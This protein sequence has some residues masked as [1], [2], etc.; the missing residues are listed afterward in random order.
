[1]NRAAAVVAALSLAS[2]SA[3]RIARADSSAEDMATARK[4]FNQGKELRDKGDLK[5]ALEKFKQAHALGTTPITGYELGKT[6]LQL[7]Q[8]VEAREAFLSVARLE[9]AK[10]E[11]K[12][13]AKARAESEKLADDL[14]AR[15][16]TVHVVLD[17]L[18]AGATPTV[19]IDGVALPATAVNVPYAVNPGKH[20][21]LVTVQGAEGDAKGNVEVKEGE[22]KDVTV[23]VSAL[24]PVQKP[25]VTTTTTTLPP[26]PPPE[27]KSVSPLVFIGFGVGAAGLIA[28]GVTGLMSMSKASTVKDQCDGN[29]CP[30]TVQ[31]DLD[32]GKTL[33]TIST[34]S[35]AVGAAGIVVGVIGLAMGGS[36]S[37]SDS[38]DKSAKVH[39]TP[40]I[41]LGSA[42]LSGAF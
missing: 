14:K 11:S 26:P 27:K 19:S 18:A 40:W 37:K 35:F 7:G 17:G 30:R 29:T 33:G 16:P 1:M 42:G 8:L 3:P 31:S 20:D 38:G 15:I 12:N 39:V 34:I 21:I 36:S 13:S 10:D 25:V 4:L 24:K 23:D 28:G 9:V 32:S 22:A 2:A 5:G 6:H 41:G